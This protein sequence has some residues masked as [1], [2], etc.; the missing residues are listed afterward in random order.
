MPDLTRIS[1]RRSVYGNDHSPIAILPALLVVLVLLP[2]LPARAQQQS[3]PALDGPQ[4][5]D[6]QSGQ[7]L[8]VPFATGLF[9]PWRLAF[10]DARTILLTERNGRLRMI[11]DGILAQEPVWTSPTPPGNGN[12]ALHF[13]AIHPQFA[14]NQLV[15]VSYP[16]RGE[17]G[18]TLAVA[19][20]RLSGAKLT[21][22]QEIF[23]ARRLGDRRQ[24]G[25][26]DLLHPGKPALCDRG[27]PRPPLLQR[28]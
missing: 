7:I 5:L 14:Q 16:K 25:G 28:R 6:V 13:L 3:T 19:R 17:H 2:S 18:I 11:R 1:L 23:V 15:Y 20:G 22:V 8:V 27:R 21:D 26:P 12:D 4:I 10:T 24:S 9:H